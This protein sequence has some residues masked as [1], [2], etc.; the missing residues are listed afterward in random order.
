M[1]KIV[2][3][4][5]QIIFAYLI[6]LQLGGCAWTDPVVA[7]LSTLSDGWN[8]IGGGEDAVCSDGSDYQFFARPGD[9]SKLLIYFQ[10]GGACWNSATCDPDL[11]P[12]YVRMQNFDPTRSNGIFLFTEP[13]NP[14]RNHSVIVAPYCSGDLHMGDR[15]VEYEGPE[16]EDHESHDFV[17]QHRGFANAQAVL[18]WTF[19]HFF[20]PSSIFVTGSSAGSISSPYYAML[21]A[22]QYPDAEL[23]QLGDGSSGYRREYMVV[24][25]EETWGTLDR[26]K[27]MPEFVGVVTENFSNERLYIAAATRHPNLQFAAFDHAEDRVQKQFLALAGYRADSLLRLILANQ[28]DIRDSVPRYNSYIAGGDL[29]TILQRPEFYTQHVEGA[30][31][32]DWV[33]ALARHEPVVNVQCSSC[34]EGEFSSVDEGI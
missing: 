1:P 22:D 24:T 23:T 8:E 7:D 16:T 15:V 25:P 33:A 2:A 18:D 31:V 30:S 3:I 26:L 19:S 9:P 5:G 14:F 32:R 34:L 11:D 27:Q 28:A 17:V 13:D 12:T 21:V 6:F 4:A 10:G 20:Q 29:H